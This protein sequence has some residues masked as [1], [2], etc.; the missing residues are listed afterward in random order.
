MGP[1]N[2]KTNKKNN[3]NSNNNNNNNNNNK[4]N[5]N[6]IDLF[7]LKIYLQQNDRK[8]VN[9]IF[10]DVI[11]CSMLYITFY[12]PRV[13]LKF[14]KFVKYR[15]IPP[16]RI[17]VKRA[18]LMGLYSGGEGGSNMIPVGRS[19]VSYDFLVV[20]IFISKYL[21]HSLETILLLFLF[22]SKIR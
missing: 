14:L 12:C 18:N 8:T 19:P 5:N 15:L 1:R 22:N 20:F 11:G 9:V 10:C 3:N 2:S 17:Y 21:Y 13:V 7:L 16:G 4:N 6:N